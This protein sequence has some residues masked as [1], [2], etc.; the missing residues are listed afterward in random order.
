M[1]VYSVL[2]GP[3]Y[4][5]ACRAPSLSLVRVHMEVKTVWAFR[6]PV[7]VFTFQSRDHRGDGN[8]KGRFAIRK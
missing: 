5:C 4:T 3:S 7:Q 2:N 8:L 1:E 6:N